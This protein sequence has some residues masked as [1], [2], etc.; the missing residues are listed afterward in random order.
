MSRSRFI[1][2]KC[3][4]K[5]TPTADQ[6][7]RSPALWRRWR[8]DRALEP[9]D[10]AL[11]GRGERF[12]ETSPVMRFFFGFLVLT[13]IAAL[14]GFGGMGDYSWDGARR[15]FYLFLGDGKIAAAT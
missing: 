6:T 8:D 9:C 13:A 4:S 12:Q 7:C 1:G 5:F 10:R 14:F 11:A 2:R 15:F 3:G